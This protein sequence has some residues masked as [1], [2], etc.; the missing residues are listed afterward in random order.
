M[1]STEQLYVGYRRKPLLSD[2]LDLHIEPGH[3]WGIVG[4]NGAGKTTLLKTLLGLI[5]PISGRVIKPAAL[6]IGYVPQRNQ[7]NTIFPL[8][9]FDLVSMGL[10]NRSGIQ[11]RLPRSQHQRVIEWIERVGLAPQHN[12]LL[13]ELSGGQRQR[14]LVARA[15]VND[16][17]LLILDE[18]TDG[19]DLLAESDLFSLIE[20]LRETRQL[21]IIIVSHRLS[22]VAMRAKQILLLQNGSFVSGE[23]HKL[24][25]P[26]YLSSLYGRE[27]RQIEIEGKPVL[28][29]PESG[30]L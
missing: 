24:L 6:R 2:P 27:V 18:P 10:L 9:V 4:P 5:P 12:T 25:Q 8:N 11:W 28:Y 13:R 20:K 15:L 1:L 17:D 26:Q 23:S 29:A 14:A 21:S 16:P 30:P 19:L 22:L 3:F 7:L